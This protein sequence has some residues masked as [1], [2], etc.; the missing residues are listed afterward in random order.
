LVAMHVSALPIFNVLIHY[1]ALAVWAMV[2]S[3]LCV[4][5]DVSLSWSLLE[6]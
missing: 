6:N 1:T 3:K 4:D 5:M 2:H